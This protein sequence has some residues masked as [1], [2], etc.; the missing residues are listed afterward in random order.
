MRYSMDY[1]A[2]RGTP[3][4]EIVAALI[5]AQ[6]MLA[7]SETDPSPALAMMPYS[8]DEG[9]PLLNPVML[10][11]AAFLKN[12]GIGLAVDQPLGLLFYDPAAI[13]KVLRRYPQIAT[14]VEKGVFDFDYLCEALVL[15]GFEVANVYI[16]Q[17]HGS[18][19]YY[20][21][22]RKRWWH[23]PKKPWW[24]RLSRE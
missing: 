19:T 18:L 3:D 12:Q 16:H 14:L 7:G 9:T 11:A 6:S 8:M 23:W 4:R 20:Q 10:G 2:E 13:R 21:R 17:E 5:Q 1:T 15:E 22:F 24:H